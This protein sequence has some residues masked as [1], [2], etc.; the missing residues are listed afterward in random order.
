M[1]STAPASLQSTAPM[2]FLGQW[3]PHTS[4]E[5]PNGLGFGF[6][7]G[8]ANRPRQKLLFATDWG[9]TKDRG[10]VGDDRIVRLEGSWTCRLMEW[11]IHGL[12]TPTR[13]P[14]F[15]TESM[16]P[17]VRGSSLEL[18]CQMGRLPQILLFILDQPEILLPIFKHWITAIMFIIPIIVSLFLKRSMW[19]HVRKHLQ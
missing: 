13:C 8:P 9:A 4:P 18:W 14:L 15:G 17:V 16:S 19:K 5:I 7:L 11:F 1:Q 12:Q 2:Y 3:G 10:S 6:G